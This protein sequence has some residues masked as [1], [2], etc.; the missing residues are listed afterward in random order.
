VPKNTPAEII[1]KLNK[2]INAK[3]G[4]KAMKARDVMMSPVITAKPHST[5]KEVAKT[6]LEKQISAV[7]VV[8]DAGKLVGMVSEGD[9]MHRSEA[10]TERQRSWWVRLMAGNDSLAADYIKAH[11]RKVADVM[12]PNVITA[13]PETP[14]DEIAILLEKNSIKRVPIVKDGQL[15]GIVSRANLVQAVASAP[16]G[17]EIPLSDSTIRDKLLA[18]LKAQPWALTDLLNV[19][20]NDGVVTLWG[21]TG[22][23]T[24]RKAIRVAAEA[25]PGVRT[26]ND[27]LTLRP[28]GYGV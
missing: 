19:T 1:D 23:E 25:T 9:L 11:G 13:T 26:V 12:T 16:K 15:V 24:E 14:L 27:H 17:L 8:D 7:P 3:V 28:S 10:G 5:V 18:H 21:I 4:G 22:S 2:E 20:V 6:L